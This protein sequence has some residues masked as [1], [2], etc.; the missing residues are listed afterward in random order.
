MVTVVIPCFN[1]AQYIYKCISSLENQ[2]YHN[3]KV[4]FVDDNSTDDT[5]SQLL[6]LQKIS[7]LNIKVLLNAQNSGPAISR[8]RGILEVDTKYIAFCDC[9]DWYEPNF[10][11]EM[12]GLLESNS[13]DLAFCGHKVVDENGSALMRPVFNKSGIISK[14]QVYSLDAD[15]LCM[16]MVKSDIMKTTLLPNLRNGEDMA[17]VPLLI[18]KANIYVVSEKCLY[19][20]FRRSDSASEMIKVEVVDSLL[21]SFDYL[22]QN[23]PSDLHIELE[24]IG[25]KYVLYSS[26]I[27]L[28][29]IG[30]YRK[31][32]LLI[33]Y[34]FEKNYPNWKNNPYLGGMRFYKRLVIFLVKLKCLYCI[35]VV[36]IVRKSLF[37]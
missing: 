22:K 35:R 28:F 17:V 36:A 30:F 37:K 11:E 19:N 14:E 29:T 13:A 3:F 31:K 7:H 15:S 25:I 26:I 1:A 9:D 8:N 12:V 6:E 4:I 5:Y 20:Y 34:N 27:T 24:Y 32:A 23:F 33:L 21:F 10:I 16:L 18:A 2:T